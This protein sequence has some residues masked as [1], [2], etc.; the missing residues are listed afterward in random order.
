MYLIGPFVGLIHSFTHS[1]TVMLDIWW[2]ICWTFG[3][4]S[5]SSS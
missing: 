5:G 1:L 4:K 2:Y 3:V